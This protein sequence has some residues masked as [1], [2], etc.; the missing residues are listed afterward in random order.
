MPDSPP[1]S[2]CTGLT[3]PVPARRQRH[4]GREDAGGLATSF[5]S[6]L[7]ESGADAVL[8]TPRVEKLD[9]VG[10]NRWPGRRLL[11]VPTNVVDP[12]PCAG[13]AAD[14]ATTRSVTEA[15]CLM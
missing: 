6:A 5:A 8:A 15:P 10:E 7:A 9:A 12:D 3:N 4:S 13:P 11:A 1:A 2:Y 14:R